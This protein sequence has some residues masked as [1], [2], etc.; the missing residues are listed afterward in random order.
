M[1]AASANGAAPDELTGTTVMS[2]NPSFSARLAIVNKANFDVSP[3][4]VIFT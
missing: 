1:A 2:K 3:P 4:T